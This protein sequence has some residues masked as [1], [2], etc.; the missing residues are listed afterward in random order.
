MGDEPVKSCGHESPTVFQILTI[1]DKLKVRP[2]Q[3]T[4]PKDHKVTQK[5]RYETEW[6][7]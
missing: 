3:C 5:H 1:G 7:R 6:S 2:V 4:L